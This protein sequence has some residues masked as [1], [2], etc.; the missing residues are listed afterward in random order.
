M[1]KMMLVTMM[2][3]VMVVKQ[4]ILVLP[5]IEPLGDRRCCQHPQAHLQLDDPHLILI[6]LDWNWIKI[7]GLFL[8]AIIIMHRYLEAASC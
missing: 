1:V 6:I 4:V 7:S 8:V 3:M 5:A 2:I